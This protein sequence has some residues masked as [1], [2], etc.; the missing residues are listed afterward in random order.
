[1]AKLVAHMR[2]IAGAL[3]LA[4]LMLPIVIRTTEEMLRL[5]P[6]EL[7]H[8]SDALGARIALCGAISATGAFGMV[9]TTL[10]GRI[11]RR[12]A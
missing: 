1:M 8:G 4:C 7:R 2:L 11:R 10:V 6:T 3:A 9:V 5:V 12:S